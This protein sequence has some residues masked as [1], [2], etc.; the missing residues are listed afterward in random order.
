LVEYGR[1]WENRRLWYV[2]VASEANQ[3]RLEQVQAGMQQ[4]ADPRRGDAAAADALV[5]EL[6]AVAWLAYCVHGDE[7]S[8]SDAALQLLYHLVAAQN[9]AV[10]RSVLANCVVIVD[11]L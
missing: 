5:E 6:P 7:P 2:V 11:P 8:G 10:A 1:S 9:D 3:H 4:L